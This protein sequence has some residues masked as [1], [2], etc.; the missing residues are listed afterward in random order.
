M[1]HFFHSSFFTSLAYQETGQDT[2]PPHFPQ[3]NHNTHHT[4]RP[5]TPPD[6]STSPSTPLKTHRPQTG[7]AEQDARTTSKTFHAREKKR[8]QFTDAISGEEEEEEE[9]E[10]FDHGEIM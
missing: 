2:T 8:T 6:T 5:S 1:L 7:L 9:E 4:P 10:E 3:H